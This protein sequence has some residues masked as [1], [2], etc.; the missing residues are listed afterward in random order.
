MLSD[1]Q[2]REVFILRIE[3]FMKYLNTEIEIKNQ[4]I[5]KHSYDFNL[6]IK[7]HSD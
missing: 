2:V 7:C 1:F 5:L 6:V 4:Q 3:K